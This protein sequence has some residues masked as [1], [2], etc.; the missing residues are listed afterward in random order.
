M[1]RPFG[2]AEELE[3]RRR[4][5]VDLVRRGEKPTAVARILGVDRPSLYRWRREAERGADALAAR[6]HPHRPPALR[7]EQL[8]RLA[9]L[10][11]QGAQAHGWPNALWTC[12]R[13]AHLIARHF[14]VGYHHDHV[15]R[16][17]RQRLG[18]S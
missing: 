11:A 3:R 6:P 4:H 10:L 9:G 14:H 7:D 5:A 8:R 18:W 2:T 12:A 15:G 13:V 17:L 1:S 16:F